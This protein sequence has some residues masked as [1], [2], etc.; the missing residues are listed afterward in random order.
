LKILVVQDY[1]RSG[2][3]ERQ[4]CTLA[5]A[6]AEAGHQVMLLTFRPGGPLSVLPSNRVLRQ[7]LQTSDL[8]WDWFAPGLIRAARRFDPDAILCMGRMANCY[9]WLLSARLPKAAVVATLRTG[10]SLPWLFRR[11]LRRARHVV[12]N[13]HETRERVLAAGQATPERVSVIHNSLVFA[14]SPPPPNRNALRRE[15]GVPDDAVLLLWVG[16]FRPEKNH[17]E[18]LDLVAR[19]PAGLPW[20]FWLVGDGPTKDRLVRWTEERGLSARIQFL[21]FQPNPTALYPLADL[22]VMTSRSESLSNFL[23]EAHAHGLPSLAYAA[24]GVAECGGTVV[25]MGDQQAFLGA[26]EKRVADPAFRRQESARVRQ[27]ALDAFSPEKQTRA[28]L[29]LFQRLLAPSP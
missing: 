16:M 17:Q 1:L 21:G 14:P 20:H 13:S 2:G 8:G 9:G 7:V 4:S 22:A 15:R 24:S 19:L 25:P 18:C 3:T 23:I 26:L 10:K 28:Y 11:T 12:A 6:F 5:N 29:D 27:F